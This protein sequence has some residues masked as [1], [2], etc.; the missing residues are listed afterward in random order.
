MKKILSL[1]IIAGIGFSAC[2]E[3][4]E[5]EGSKNSKP[6]IIIIVADDLGFSDISPYG[7]NIQ[8][9]VI[10]KFSKESK[11]FS[12]FHVPCPSFSPAAFSSSMTPAGLI[13]KL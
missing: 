7:G 1:I 9:P 2:N 4:K 6:N 3:T 13:L 11:L 12:N 5:K 8:T 10:D